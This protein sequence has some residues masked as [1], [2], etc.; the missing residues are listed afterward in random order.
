MQLYNDQFEKFWILLHDDQF[1]K[2]G[3]A[4]KKKKSHLVAQS[5][6]HN[7]IPRAFETNYIHQTI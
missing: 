6:I 4:L 3:V 7:P 1:G 2:E 5:N